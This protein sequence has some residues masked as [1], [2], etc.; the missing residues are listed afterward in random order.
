MIDNGSAADAAP[1]AILTDAGLASLTNTK[2]QQHNRDAM[3]YQ[4]M[5]DRM[6]AHLTHLEFEGDI[7][8]ISARVRAWKVARRARRMSRW[9]RKIAKENQALYSTH[10]K[11]VTRLPQR[12]AARALKKA[13]QQAPAVAQFNPT[14]QLNGTAQYLSPTPPTIPGPAPVVSQAGSWSIYEEFPRQEAQ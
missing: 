9:S 8:G 11:Q 7:R 10:N 13:G 4:A 3:H 1:D 14:I 6:S 12:R 5:A 2:R